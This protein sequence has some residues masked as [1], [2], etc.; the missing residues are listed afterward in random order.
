S[1]STLNATTAVL[2]GLRDIS[3]ILGEG[4][5]YSPSVYYCVRQCDTIPGGQPQFAGLGVNPDGTGGTLTSHSAGWYDNS[6]RRNLEPG[7]FRSVRLV[8][9]HHAGDLSAPTSR[10]AN[11]GQ[12]G[13]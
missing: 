2:G 11:L 8:H 13:S 1:S 3:G 6:C 9:V 7:R 12:S 5:G 4:D 10:A